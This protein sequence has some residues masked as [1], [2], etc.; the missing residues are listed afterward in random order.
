MN[1]LIK[2]S[3]NEINGCVV[4]TVNAKEIWLYLESKQRFPDWMK[5]RIRTYEFTQAVDFVVNH[6]FMI[7]ET[8]FGGKR[9]VTEFHVSI[10]MAKE[11]SMVERTERG[12]QARRYFIECERL[13]K[14]A[15]PAP[16]FLLPTNFVEALEF[17]VVAEKTK[18]VLIEKIETD[19]P[20]VEFA[21]AVSEAG[22][23]SIGEFAKILKIKGVGRN[24]LFKM[25]IELGYLM[26]NTN[27]A[28]YQKYINSGLFERIELTPYRNS[29]GKL[30]PAFK[31][32]ITGKGQ[33][34][35]EKRLRPIAAKAA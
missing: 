13:T 8:A 18:L 33:I 17:L 10:D 29:Y 12:K 11:L 26:P 23:C 14:L 20:L 1:E 7:D 25:L 31:T 19:K 30:V 32:V 22:G 9:K 34:A 28:P 2:L 35:I 27:N 5:D 24:T 15:P 21:I 4:D 3:K 16:L 6:T